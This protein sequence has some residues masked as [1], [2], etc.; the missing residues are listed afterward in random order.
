MPEGFTPN[1]PLPKSKPQFI[2]GKWY[3]S[4]YSGSGILTYYFIKVTEIISKTLIKGETINCSRQFSKQDYWN[5]ED[6]LKQALELGP[7]TSLSEIQQY[8][9]EGHP[10]KYM[11]DEFKVTI[12]QLTVLPEKWCI[13]ITSENENL[14]CDY[15]IKQNRCS[16]IGTGWLDHNLTWFCLNNK[17]SYTEISFDDFKRLVLKESIDYKISTISDEDECEKWFKKWFKKDTLLQSNKMIK[18]SVN[19]E[20]TIKLVTKQQLITI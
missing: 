7:L 9:P 11:M 10:D 1:I 17:P 14:L 13:K 4:N 6:S 18:V 12:K 20:S 5:S 8:L 19:N 16:F 2:V 15:R 3:K